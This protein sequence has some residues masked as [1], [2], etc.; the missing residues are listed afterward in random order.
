[1]RRRLPSM[2][3][4]PPSVAMIHFRAIGSNTFFVLPS[5]PS[6]PT[7]I[8]NRSYWSVCCDGFRLDFFIHL[9]EPFLWDF[10]VTC[11]VWCSL[12]RIFFGSSW[13]WVFVSAPPYSSCVIVIYFLLFSFGA[14]LIVPVSAVDL[15]RIYSLVFFMLISSFRR[16]EHSW[17]L[18]R[19]FSSVMFPFQGAPTWYFF[20]IS[21]SL[22]PWLFPSNPPSPPHPTIIFSV[23]SSG[24]LEYRKKWL[25]P[26]DFSVFSPASFLKFFSWF[27]WQN[28]YPKWSLSSVL[29]PSFAAYCNFWLDWLLLLP[30][31][32]WCA[33]Y[34]YSLNC[35]QM[36]QPWVL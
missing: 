33:V 27:G 28:P 32:L 6:G 4:A 5:G 24:C 7:C 35:P 31:F 25:R 13:R 11:S 8:D 22:T 20:M 12:I 30:H 36:I 19:Q 26:S 1:M 2:L 29:V 18:V 3:C 14:F 15:N 10:L 21:S 16:W 9:N 34:L 17:L 23:V